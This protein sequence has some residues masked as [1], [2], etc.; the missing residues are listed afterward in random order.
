MNNEPL[1]SPLVDSLLARCTFP[2]PGTAAD[3]AVS[4][5]PDSMALLVLAVA[6][7]L[8]VTAVHV[9]HSIRPG[10]ARDA[11]LIAAVA[12]RLGAK[13]VT[14]TVT[15][16]PGPNLEARARQARFAALP[17]G[18]MTGHTADD[19]AE[20]VLI[21]LLRGAGTAGLSAMEPGTAH[22][23]LA[24][25]REETHALCREL[26]FTTVHDETNDDPAHQRN[27]V[28]S[29]LL[30][31]LATISRRDPVPILV[32]TADVMRDDGALL[33]ELASQI[34]PTDAPALAAA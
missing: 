15:V 32:R 26:G 13:F 25:R 14:R 24:L 16:E 31:L 5:G 12:A 4:G 7:G 11:E 28:R 1:R 23:L 6:H 27:R 20:T 8:D 2:A 17:T 10:S 29:E 3:C 19:Q 33:D 34:D 18:S 30:P 22:P 9:D 21:N